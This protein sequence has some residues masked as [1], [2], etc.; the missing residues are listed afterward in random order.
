MDANIA[1]DGY[2]IFIS[3]FTK[4]NGLATSGAYQ[5]SINGDT[6][7]FLTKF[8]TAG[9]VIWA[10]YFGGSGNDYATSVMLDKD[11]NIYLTG[12]T[13]SMSGIATTGAFQT[14]YGGGGADGF[15]AKFDKNGF[16]LWGTYFGGAG[17]DGGVRLA[18]DSFGNVFMRGGTNSLS[19]I[20]TSGT[21]Q[22]SYFRQ[23][24][25]IG[26]GTPLKLLSQSSMVQG[27][28]Y[29]QPITMIITTM[30]MYRVLSLIIRVMYL[31]PAPGIIP[32]TLPKASPISNWA[33]EATRKLIYP[34]LIHPVNF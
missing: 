27:R 25:D 20:A 16:P 24:N 12:G 1:T 7:A 33:L 14:S 2:S 23:A 22:T 26:L 11:G 30:I 32:Q 5:T 34:N 8:D 28:G 31:S 21:Y 3:G 13:N 19:G 17:M 18:T 4:Q 6:D 9:N 29:G 10:T 15:L